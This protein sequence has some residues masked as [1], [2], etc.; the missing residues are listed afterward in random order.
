V[1]A[2][3]RWYSAAVVIL[4]AAA[5]I[6]LHQLGAGA[7]VADMAQRSALTRA[8][9]S[10]V[11][12]VDVCR[13]AE[14]N[15]GLIV[16]QMVEHGVLWFPRE[17]GQVPMRKPPLH[18][19][20]TAAIAYFNGTTEV[21]AF[22][23]RLPSVML[24][25]AGIALTIG[26][27]WKLLGP[28]AGVLAGL[29][30]AATHQYMQRGRAGRPDIAV[31]FFDTLA[32]MSFV[33]WLALQDA[34]AGSRDETRRRVAHYL[35]AVALGLAVLSRGPIGLALPG[36]A[37]VIW[38]AWKRRWQTLR[39]LCRPGPLM[40]GATL[41]LGW[42]VFCLVAGRTDFLI[43][44]L[45]TEN[46]TRFTGGLGTQSRWYYLLR[47]PFISFPFGLLAPIAIGM[48]LWEPKAE[49]AARREALA[50]G[51][52]RLF[53]MYWIVTI[54]VLSFAAFKERYY[55]VPLWPATA[56]MAAWLVESKVSFRFRPWAYRV[57]A[58][59]CIA[60]LAVNFYFLPYEAARDCVGRDFRRAAAEINHIVPANAPLYSHRFPQGLIGSLAPLLFY[61]DRTAPLL[62]VRLADAPPGYI[63]VSTGGRQPEGSLPRGFEVIARVSLGSN[64]VVVLRRAEPAVAQPAAR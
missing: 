47:L 51:S 21:D 24:A 12:G 40:A 50:R 44:Q 28:R 18:L 19:W 1:R 57:A 55:L 30:L 5:A 14:G 45:G 16:Q 11:T 13:D 60:I 27:A 48:A 6:E 34:E 29:M 56:V 7:C 10:F 54:A 36:L 8:W 25:L 20:L 49:A 33:W 38:I 53:A 61:L 63:M 58:A 23:L 46:L 37:I 42:Y 4:A 41:A 15:Q 9:C 3:V 64:G 39:A 62:D 26:F 2:Q 32:L 22:D 43:E 31:T 52:M 59:V 35:F 17:N